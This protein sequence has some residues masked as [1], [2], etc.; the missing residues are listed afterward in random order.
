MSHTS[1]KAENVIRAIDDNA[2]SAGLVPIFVDPISGRFT[3]REI[4]LGSR[5]DW[6]YGGRGGGGAASGAE[7]KRSRSEQIVQVVEVV[8]VLSRLWLVSGCLW[9]GSGSVSFLC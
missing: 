9:S 5:G 3:T 4:R 6:Y 8:E 7:A 1:C 2:A